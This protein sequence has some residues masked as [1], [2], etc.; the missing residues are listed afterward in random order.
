MEF[1]LGG[2]LDDGEANGPRAERE[3]YTLTELGDTGEV[4]YPDIEVEWHPNAEALFP[5]GRYI[6]HKTK[7]MPELAI[8]VVE[9]NFTHVCWLPLVRDNVQVRGSLSD[10]GAIDITLSKRD[11]DLGKITHGRMLRAW[12]RGKL[13]ATALVNQPRVDTTY[14]PPGNES[15]QAVQIAAQGSRS[16]LDGVVVHPWK[17]EWL[18]SSNSHNF[19]WTHPSFDNSKWQRSYIKA[20][21][22]IR[23]EDTPWSGF[24]RS[25]PAP[26]A[27]WIGG[28]RGTWWSAG[29]YPTYLT[30]DFTITGD[31]FALFW[32][33]DNSAQIFIDGVELGRVENWQQTQRVDL[34]LNGGTHRIAARIANWPKWTPGPNPT[35]LLVALF[36]TGSQGRLGN[37]VLKSDATWK[38]LQNPKSVPGWTPG[39]VLRWLFSQSNGRGEPNNRTIKTSFTDTVDTAGKRW[40]VVPEISIAVGATYEQV[41]QQLSESYVDIEMSPGAWVLHAWNKGGKGRNR[42]LTLGTPSTAGV[43]EVNAS[44]VE[45]SHRS[46]PPIASSLV[47]RYRDNWTRKSVVPPAGFH[48]REAHLQ[49][50][51]IKTR[52][53]AIA[54][55]ERLLNLYGRERVEFSA[56][57]RPRNNAQTPGIGFT[58]G[59]FIFLPDRNGNLDRV[60]VLSWEIAMDNNGLVTYQIEAGDLITYATEQI[61]RWL[62]RMADGALQGVSPQSMPTRPDTFQY[63]SSSLPSTPITFERTATVTDP[64]S[65]P[66][67][68]DN[69]SLIVDFSARLGTGTPVRST[70]VVCSVQINGKTVG[71]CTIPAGQRKGQA[72]GMART[73]N[74][75]D[76]VTVQI[77][78]IG[79]TVVAVVRFA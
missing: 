3:S 44:I 38:S 69:F 62:Q 24:P 70:N 29:W 17:L 55:A 79:F 73:V 16:E 67:P 6:P 8:E 37:L 4:G 19:N 49:V 18:P 65:H 50:P 54:L 9:K 41:L 60:R 40:P 56:Q 46:A 51:H 64:K 1:T 61:D 74:R 52:D 28:I 78:Q 43:T 63:S 48:R 20:R 15:G 45:L 23:R 47:M 33:G 21:Q 14:L 58:Y 22:G 36:R 5:V 34:T 59:D 68:V 72:Q 30:R 26:N 32:A 2:L 75:G 71:T 35:G 39:R 53:G 10:P 42:S 13:I 11:P 25:W 77:D 66:F 7:V 31:T 57:L 12:L 27:Y 76:D